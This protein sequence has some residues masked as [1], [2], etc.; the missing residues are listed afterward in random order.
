MDKLL[1]FSNVPWSCGKGREVENTEEIR[2]GLPEVAD[3]AQI[4]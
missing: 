4:T 1:D 3:I 2:G